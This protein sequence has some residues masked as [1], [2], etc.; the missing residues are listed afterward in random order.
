MEEYGEKFD[1]VTI[2]QAL[3]WLPLPDVLQHISKKLLNPDGR[4][5]VFSYCVQ[6]IK[7]LSGQ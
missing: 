1:L 3:H 6:G 7:E 2:G 5:V 4:F